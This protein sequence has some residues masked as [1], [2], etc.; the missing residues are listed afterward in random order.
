MNLETRTSKQLESIGAIFRSV[1]S[2][3]ISYFLRANFFDMV[4]VTG[5]IPVAP[6]IF[7][8]VKSKLL[9]RQRP[10]VFEPRRHRK[11]TGS[12]RSELVARV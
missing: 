7:I 4:G 12:N 10:V 1:D 8:L 2:N 3:K 11:H 6:T 5:S 9:I